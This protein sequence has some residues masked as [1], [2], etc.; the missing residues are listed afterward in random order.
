MQLLPQ[1]SEVLVV[2]GME[3]AQGVVVAADDD[4]VEVLYVDKGLSVEM[5]AGIAAL[6][7]EDF[8]CSYFFIGEL[9]RML[10]ES[11]HR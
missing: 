8:N 3:D 9:N 6:G 4:A 7:N 10:A 11:G 1:G 5:D 2:G